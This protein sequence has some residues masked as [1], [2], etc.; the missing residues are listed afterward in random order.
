[1]NVIDQHQQK[2][3]IHIQNDQ[4]ISRKSQSILK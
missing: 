1:M 4:H 3:K 2:D